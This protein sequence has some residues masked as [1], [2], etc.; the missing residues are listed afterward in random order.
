MT[1]PGL[2]AKIRKMSWERIRNNIAF[3][4]VVAFLALNLFVTQD[5]EKNPLSRFAA[6]RAITEQGTFRIDDYKDWTIDWSQGPDGHYYSNKAP[7]SILLAVPAFWVIDKAALLWEMDNFD[8]RGLRKA[9]GY[10]QKT[11]LSFLLQALPFALLVIFWAEALAAAGASAGAL[12]FLSLSLLFGQT[13]ALFM[14]SWFGHGFAAMLLLWAIYEWWKGR[15]FR[16]GFALGLTLLSEYQTAVLFPFLLLLPL[17]RE[18]ARERSEQVPL[19]YGRLRFVPAAVAGGLVPAALW[20][21]YHVSAFGGP[22]A[23][24]AQYYN[25]AFKDMADTAGNLMGVLSGAPRL[26]I[27][28][29]LLFGGSRGILVTQPW[30]LVAAAGAAFAI[31]SRRFVAR[32]ATAQLT[33]CL[34]AATIALLLFNSMVGSWNAGYAAGPR[35]LSF[36]FPAWAV[37]A[38][39]LHDA[40]GARWK[41]ALWAGLGVA[42]VFRALVYGTTILAPDAPLWPWLAEKFLDTGSGTPWLR[43]GIFAAMLALAWLWVR[44]RNAATV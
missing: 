25:P 29:A 9:P 1:L 21:W 17:L 27:V 18:R 22:F 14:N 42:L 24:P 4:W 16:F 44:K 35:Y 26:E 15:D 23:M 19:G 36:I 34:G 41:R 43:L 7:G 11:A 5:G 30:V 28:T 38:A 12:H 3:P 37:L 10:F 8:E 13:A 39:L 31:A 40:L 2:L 32:A 6:L 33:L 20:I